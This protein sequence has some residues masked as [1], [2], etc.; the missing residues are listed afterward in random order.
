MMDGN[1]LVIMT[2]ELVAAGVSISDINSARFHIL[3]MNPTRTR[4]NKRLL[5]LEGIR[6][7]SLTLVL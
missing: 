3:E 2:E 7:S 5:T 1:A 4:P 6:E